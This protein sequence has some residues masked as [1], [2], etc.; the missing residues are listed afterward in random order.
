MLIK[1]RC[2]QA[3]PGFLWLGNRG[4]LF[5]AAGNLIAS[6]AHRRTNIQSA[7]G[8]PLLSCDIKIATLSRPPRALSQLSLAREAPA[9]PL[10]EAVDEFTQTRDSV[11]LTQQPRQVSADITALGSARCPHAAAHTKALGSM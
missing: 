8:A 9:S 7:A 5:T 3:P 10:A 6:R 1:D 2:A 4:P 11:G